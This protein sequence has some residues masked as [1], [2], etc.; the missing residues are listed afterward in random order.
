MSFH[1]ECTNCGA[2]LQLAE[3]QRTV[4]CPF[5]ALPSV[6]E[7]PPRPEQPNPLFAVAFV[8]TRERAQEAVRAWARSRGF[9]SH[10]GLRTAREEDLRGVYL[11]AYL[12]SSEAHTTFSALIG[13]NYTETEYYWTKDE[14]GNRV[15]RARTVVKTEWRPFSGQHATY[16]F[17]VLVTASR[18]VANLDLE[19]LE[20][21]DLRFLRRYSAALLSGWLAE[22]PSLTVAEC[23]GLARSEAQ[24]HLAAEL[25]RF[26]PGDTH[27]QLQFAVSFARESLELVLVPVWVLALRYDPEK[28]P[29]RVL[30]NGQ[31]GAVHGKAPLSALRIALAVLLALGAIALLVLVSGRNG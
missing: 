25:P 10:R 2:G 30:V 14:K 22:E 11:P 28:P 21:F 20:P 29:L 31:T 4:L 3:T 27:Q 13:E 1:L 19:A 6:V 7:R 23:A 16:L 24:A 17:D 15:Q 9:F 5:C 12:Y 26:M 18:S 8:L